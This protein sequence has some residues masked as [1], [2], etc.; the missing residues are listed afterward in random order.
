MRDQLAGGGTQRNDERNDEHAAAIE[1]IQRQ[2]R[3]FMQRRQRQPNFLEGP[4]VQ[5]YEDRDPEYV[6]GLHGS[7][8]LPAAAGSDD[9]PPH[10]LAPLRYKARG[11]RWLDNELS[12]Q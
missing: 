2:T 7:P 5:L 9:A 11:Q 12:Q 1:V 8:L 3:R 10:R 4:V 6:P